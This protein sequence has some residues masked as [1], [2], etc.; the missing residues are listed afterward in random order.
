LDPVYQIAT[1][2]IDAFAV[3]RPVQL[4]KSLLKQEMIMR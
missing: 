3:T 2:F 4:E 1:Y